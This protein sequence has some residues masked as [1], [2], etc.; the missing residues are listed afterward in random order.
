LE[1]RKESSE[2]ND[3]VSHGIWSSGFKGTGA[4]GRYHRR[5]ASVATRAPRIT[6]DGG[7]CIPGFPA[8]RAP[9][10]GPK[11]TACG[12]P[13]I[14]PGRPAVLGGDA[15]VGPGPLDLLIRERHLD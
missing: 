9:A 5:P 12:S 6:V 2:P 14:L 3:E 11:V 7:R 4:C 1:E 15:A 8:A 10:R 13:L